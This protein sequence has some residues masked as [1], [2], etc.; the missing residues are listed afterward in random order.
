MLSI[1]QQADRRLG[2]FDLTSAQWVPLMRLKIAG[3]STVAELARW[4]NI[5]AGAMTRLL[6]R[7]E[8]K[9]L[10]RRERSTE[11]RRVVQVVLTPEGENAISAVPGVL[12]EVLNAHLSGFTNAEWQALRNFLER[13]AHNGDVLRDDV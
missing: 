2:Q 12:S 8:K 3:R 9:G 11:D 6:D 7:L 10:C 4:V 1:V 5:D 13:M